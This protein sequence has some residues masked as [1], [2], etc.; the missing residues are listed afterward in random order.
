MKTTE[1][2]YNVV[3]L[4]DAAAPARAYYVIHRQWMLA[5]AALNAALAAGRSEVVVEGV[6]YKEACAIVKLLCVSGRWMS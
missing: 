1:G 3:H 4:P 2:S 6:S 5:G